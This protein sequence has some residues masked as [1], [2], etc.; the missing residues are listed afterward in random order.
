MC[1]H[2]TYVW[3][4]INTGG[5][6]EGREHL[7]PKPGWRE[8]LWVC[9]C[10]THSGPHL[11]GSLTAAVIT[12]RP[13]RPKRLLHQT[14]ETLV[15]KTQHMALYNTP[16][17]RL[18]AGMEGNMHTLCVS[19][20]QITHKPVACEVFAWYVPFPLRDTRTS[21]SWHE[22]FPSISPGL[23]V[24]G[25]VLQKCSRL[26]L[27]ATATHGK[28]IHNSS[29]L[30]ITFLSRMFNSDRWSPAKLRYHWHLEL[31]YAEAATS[32][33]SS[34]LLEWILP[35]FNCRFFCTYPAIT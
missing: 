15:S 4:C 35:Q 8:F 33:S 12:T 31:H 26:P 23:C 25:R 10:A 20:H 13:Q 30:S 11:A 21:F 18:A 24:R 16:W 6:G 5:G 3:V 34:F 1:K 22:N 27:R 28:S 19:A 9:V 17:G 2:S 7:G 32:R 29:I 14:Q